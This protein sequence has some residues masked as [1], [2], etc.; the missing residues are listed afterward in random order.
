[1][2]DKDGFTSYRELTSDELDAA[3]MIEK[4]TIEAYA[5]RLDKSAEFWKAV[6]NKVELEGAMRQIISTE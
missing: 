5:G 1:M 4:A 3:L 6:E 2:K